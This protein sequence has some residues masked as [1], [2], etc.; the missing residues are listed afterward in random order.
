M[1]EVAEWDEGHVVSTLGPLCNKRASDWGYVAEYRRWFELLVAQARA[2]AQQE[3]ADP[4]RGT[5]PFEID[6][7]YDVHPARFVR[8]V[9]GM[10]LALQTTEH[11]FAAHPVLAELIGP[12][13]SDDSKRRVDGLDIAPL[14]LYVSVCNANWSYLTTPML[15]V[16]ANLSAESK[17]LWTPPSSTRS[18]PDDVLILCVA[19]FAFVLTT[20]N[21]SDLGQDVSHWTQW[22]VDQR[23]RKTERRLALPTADK[24]QGAIRAMIYPANYVVR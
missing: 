23:L 10:F 18:Y 1:R 15:A 7:S 11:L 6:L 19:P 21:A 2:V 12:E 8:Q 4:L 5:R 17:L 24:L 16:E 9:P 20:R 22:S 3:N 14:R 13:P